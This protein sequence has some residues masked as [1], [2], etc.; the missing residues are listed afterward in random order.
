LASADEQDARR[1]TPTRVLEPEVTDIGLTATDQD[2]TDRV[3]ANTF[4]R[5]ATNR[6]SA[7]ALLLLVLAAVGCDN[8]PDVPPP[9]P[10]PLPPQPPAAAT[11]IEAGSAAPA[12][13]IAL[14]APSDA[15]AAGTWEGSYD[16]RKGAVV[17]PDKV[18]DKTRTSDDGK[19]MVGP[20]KVELTV[21]AAGDVRGKATGAL[22]EAHL[23]GKLVDEGGGFLRASWYPEDVA[24]PNAMTGVLFG[25]V[26]DGV[27]SAMIR[28]AG[29]DAVLVRESKI[30]LKK[31]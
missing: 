12:A 21:T 7:V 3:A 29:P 15:S 16:A 10:P 23:T 28:V 17:L 20:G 2:A 26:K 22:G 13:S 5:T 8:K 6:R 9:G 14:P 24:K 27:I 4:L 1:M 25:P 18:K 31:R 30:E 11:A 19:L